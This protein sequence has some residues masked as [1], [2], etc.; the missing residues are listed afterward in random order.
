MCMYSAKDG[1]A[2]DWHLMHWGNLL[3]SGAAMFIIEATAV[4]PEGRISNGCLGLWDSSTQEGLE[5]KLHRARRL[6]PYAPV[7]IQLAHA[8]RKASSAYPWDG[9]A[10]LGQ[11]SGGW[12][13]FAPSEI[14]HLPEEPKPT[15]LDAEGIARIT[16]AF[17][18]AAQRAAALG[19]EAVEV[20]SAHGY[21]L[22]QFLSPL[23]NQRSDEYGGSFENRIRF[24]LEVVKA[25]RDVFDGVVGVRVSATDWV[26]GGW[27][28]E[29][30]TDY[31]ARLKDAGVD[32]IHVSS[33]GVSPLQKIKAGPGFQVP[34][35]RQIKERTGL[36]TIAVGLITDPTHAEDIVAR[37]DADLVAVGRGALFDPRWAWRAAATI[38]GRV[39]ATPQYWRSLPVEA[40]DIFNDTH[41]GGR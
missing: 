36:P 26:D 16:K 25:V 37:G 9:G 11:N 2:Q 13:T 34:F 35:A 29:E 33:G 22:H 7:C 5:D 10:L 32:F 12:E 15:A 41:V 20:H 14:P 19:I 40:A 39:H 8:G 18:T 30:C 31:S 17:A 3:N 1:V 6:A 24:P 27:H 28:P 21:L 4:T 23:A 38:G